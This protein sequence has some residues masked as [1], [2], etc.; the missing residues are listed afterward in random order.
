MYVKVEVV[1]MNAD[2]RREA[3]EQVKQV[4]TDAGVS[5]WINDSKELSKA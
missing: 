2:N 5:F 3:V 4:L 1:L